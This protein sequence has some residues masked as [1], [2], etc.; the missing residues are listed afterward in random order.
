MPKG[1]EQVPEKQKEHLEK[2]ELALIENWLLETNYPKER[3]ER[4]TH[5]EMGTHVLPRP[6][7]HFAMLMVSSLMIQK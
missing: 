5:R 6:R 4:Q 7:N 1:T 3:A 2:A